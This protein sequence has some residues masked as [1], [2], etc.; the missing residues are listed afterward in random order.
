[1][2]HRPRKLRKLTKEN[3]KRNPLNLPCKKSTLGH[4]QKINDFFLIL[5]EVKRKQKLPIEEQ[6]QELHDLSLE[7]MQTKENRVK[8][9]VLREKPPT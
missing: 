3:K 7:L 8:Y 6:R 5:K 9:L 2:N 1:M 4:I